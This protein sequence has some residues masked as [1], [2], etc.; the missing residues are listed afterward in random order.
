MNFL[1]AADTLGNCLDTAFKGLDLAVFSLFGNMQCDLLTALAHVFSAL[2]SPFFMIMIGVIGLALVFFKR[3]RRMGLAVIFALLASLL[4]VNIIIK[5][6]VL[7][8]RP[9]N[10]LQDIA[11]YF[12]WYQNAGMLAESDYSFPSG[13]TASAVSMAVVLCIGHIKAGKRKI[14]WVFAL[15]ALLVAASRIYL[16]IHYPTDVFAGIICGIIAGFLAYA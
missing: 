13:H 9:Y 2:A 15:E 5:P 6:M 10:T 1:C 4:L 7:R 3:S 12:G 11:S 14:A 16:M 8:I